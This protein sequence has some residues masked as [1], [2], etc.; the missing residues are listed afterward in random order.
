MLFLNTE[1]IPEEN[2]KCLMIEKTALPIKS[3]ALIDSLYSGLLFWAPLSQIRGLLK[4]D[5]YGQ[6]M[7]ISLFRN[8]MGFPVL[9]EILSRECSV[10]TR[11]SLSR[12]KRV[13]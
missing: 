1:N 3:S 6:L 8:I 5:R 13:P 11:T 7:V 2:S 9:P 4:R 10:L 12:E